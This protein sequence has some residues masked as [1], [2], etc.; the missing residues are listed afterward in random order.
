MPSPTRVD[1]ASGEAASPRGAVPSGAEVVAEAEPRS[2]PGVFQNSLTNVLG[3]VAITGLGAIA[4]IVTARTLGKEAVG[5]LAVAFG[6]GE[7]GRAISA[8]THIPSIVRYHAGDEPAVVY[9]SSLAVKLLASSL[10]VGLAIV[11]SSAAFDLFH[12]PPSVLV[13]AS[14]VLVLST[15]FEVGAARL[16]SQNR[17][18][19]S[20]LILASGSVVSLSLVLL[21]A[22]AH[23]L[24]LYTSIAATLAANLTMSVLAWRYARPRPGLIRADPRLTVEMTKYGLRIVSASLLTQGLLW[25]DTLMVSN[26]RGNGAAGVYNTVFTLTFVMVTA[27]S[28][29]GVAL[30]P[31][32][33]RLAAEGQDTARGYQRGT[34]IALAMSASIAFV[35]WIAGRLLLG[36][37]GPAFVE[38]Y[39][40]LLVLTLF[41]ISAALTVPAATMLTIHGRAGLLSLLSLAQLAVNLPLN[42]FLIR[43]YGLMGAAV[44]TTSVF[45]LGTALSWIAVQRTTG[46]WPLS[47]AA[48]VEVRQFAA[49]Q[50]RRLRA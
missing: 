12:V 22:L 10:F 50:A 21:L 48:V 41:G 39:P 45:A 33:S 49:E 40:A 19:R 2:G 4:G 3:L 25:T 44:A 28:A 15:G 46:A 30:V 20:N 37:Y 18:V 34:V 26:L 14:T 32:L 24:T 31:A 13:L 35:Y 5:I 36:L 16:E 11:F 23:H 9:G 38:G 43:D 42:Y 27:S 8:C 6:I 47:K 29:M 7:F 17:M 1:E